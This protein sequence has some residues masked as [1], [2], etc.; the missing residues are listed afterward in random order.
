MQTSGVRPVTGTSASTPRLIDLY[1]PRAEFDVVATDVVY[2]KDGERDWLARV[3]QPRGPGP[4]PA[5]VEVHGGSWTSLDRLDNAAR[6]EALARSGL[7]VMAPDF[8]LGTEAPYP[9]N[10]AEVNY[11][12]RWLKLHAAEFNATANG[13]G[14][15]GSSSGGHMVMLGAMRPHDPRYTAL[16]LDGDTDATLAYVMPI[17]GVLDP[18]ARYTQAQRLG[19]QHQITSHHQYFGDEATMLEASPQAILDRGE[20]CELPPVFIAQGA[21]DDNIA[22]RTGERFAE[23]YAQAGGL[24]ELALFP[25]AGHGFAREPG[26]FTDRMLDQMKSF[27]WRQLAALSR[28]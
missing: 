27:V 14:G 12:I 15:W 3:Y 26:P 11:A 4:F 24:V 18:Y 17:W 19:R 10:M 9:T 5:L 2:R 22:L 6:D 20:P 25:G 28:T 21:Q 23:A 7:V 16:P 1:D 13:L 8:H